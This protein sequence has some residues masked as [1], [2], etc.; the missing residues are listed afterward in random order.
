MATTKGPSVKQLAKQLDTFS[1]KIKK[2]YGELGKLE[3][4]TRE[5]AKKQ[6]ELNNAHKQAAKVNDALT[7]KQRTLI[8]NNKKH[9]SSIDAA[10]KSQKKFTDTVVR[11]S[12]ETGKAARSQKTY[13]QRLKSAIGTLSRYA[14]A[15]Q[16]LAVVQ[17]AFRALTTEA[18]KEAIKFQK[19]LANLAAVAGVSGKEVKMLGENALEVA[20]ST[21]FTADQI[22]GLQ[23]ELSKLGFTAEEVVKST[24]AIAFT[25]QALGSPLESTASTVGKVINQFNLLVEQSEFVGDVLVTS[26]NNSALSFESFGTAAQYV[27]PIARNLGLSFEQTAGAM[28]V[29]ADNGFTA[30]RIGTGLRGIFTE[31][32][33][34]SAD[35][36]KS[37]EALAKENISLS[38]AVDLVGKRNAAQLITLLQ[39]IDAINEGT[40]EYYAQGRALEA[41]SKQADTFSGQ[42]E[43]LNSN[44]KEFQI[45]IGNVIAESD[46][47]LG[48]LDAFFP[49]GAKTARAFKNINEVGFRNFNEGAEDVMKGADATA[50]ALE[51]LNIS[52]EDYQKTLDNAVVSSFA[53]ILT[54]AN[55]FALTKTRDEAI[56]TKN[57]VEGLVEQLNKLVD[58]KNRDTSISKGQAEATA[59]YGA[60]VESLIDKSLEGL[61]VN[62][63]ADDLYKE[64]ER[65]IGNYQKNLNSSNKITEDQRLQYEAAIKVLQGYQEQVNNVVISEKELQERREKGQKDALKL[66]LERIKRETKLLVDSIN[67]RA[68]IETELAETA[69]ERADI[70]AE[71]IQLVSDAYKKQSAEIRDLSKV[72]ETQIEK[73]EKAALA[74]DDLA[75]ILTSDVIKDVKTAVADYSKEIKRLDKELR[76]GQISQEEYNKARD[77]QY[78]GLLNNIE[79]FKSL[80]NVSPE[81]SALFDKI[82]KEALEAGYAINQL[83]DFTEETKK[84]F[85]DFLQGIEK[86]D[87]AKY[88]KK[89]V[90]AITESLGAFN[91]VRLEN[92][93]NELDA[94]LDLV[95]NRYETEEEI[96]K[97]QLNNQLITESQ[98]RAKQKELRQAQIAEENSV[99]KKLYDA[100]QSQD[101]NDARLEGVEAVAQAYIEAFK[102]YEPTTALI[103][104]SLGAAIAAAQSTAQIAAINQRKFFPKKFEQGGV[105]SGPSH[106]QGG[107]P[108]TVQGKGGYE[109]EGG[110]YI[111]NKRATSMHRNLLERINQSGMKRPQS[112]KYKFAE[113]GLVS[114]QANESVDYLKAIAEA[115]ATSAIQSG[116][117]VRAFVSSKDLRS[118]E[119]E[120]RLR[121]RN[122]RI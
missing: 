101:K 79:A 24:Q 117:P 18:V 71:R 61:N 32:G 27:G 51:L 64:L 81:V 113:G 90:E 1:S 80:V 110:E 100:E 21:K 69:E 78:D 59:I 2:L 38:E 49:K 62:K 91:D 88:A 48:V 53:D 40:S 35:V 30:S 55:P 106:E 4:N 115:T 44:F 63:E 112:G 60:E 111:V 31:L 7:K 87:W 17:K 66:D 120:R 75:K 65:S 94:E 6:K 68:K 107:V 5:Y 26:I 116:K 20:G 29:L 19:S 36:Q 114:A 58:S 12:R 98:F 96:L 85:E 37:L 119:T 46:L 41:A 22:V 23:T 15:Y 9:R 92:V 82:A 97:A 122:D 72:Y 50:T 57:S 52:T 86:G 108:F 73:I 28:A 74:S 16:A 103:V 56:A 34:S 89:A 67:E 8:S 121:D 54:S 45:N 95:K 11:T 99:A 13:G 105:V 70:E 76:D 14:L 3:K 84:D 118:N 42:M 39:N 102:N 25:A 33:K 77:E 93:K 83:G 47:L 10:Q 109:M 43:I 104:G